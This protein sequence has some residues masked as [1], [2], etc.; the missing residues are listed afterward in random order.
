MPVDIVVSA[1]LGCVLFMVAVPTD[2]QDDSVIL[3]KCVDIAGIAVALNKLLPRVVIG[4]NHAPARAGT[5]YAAAA[6]GDE[7]GLE[8]ALFDGGSTEEQNNVSDAEHTIA[9]KRNKR[10]Y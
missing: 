1:E 2:I 9:A 4:F 5:V 6:A 10:P 8:V 3:I 7:S